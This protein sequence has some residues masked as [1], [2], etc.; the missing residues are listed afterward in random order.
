MKGLKFYALGLCA[1][2]LFNSCNMT[3]TAKGG[4]IGGTSGAALGSALGAILAKS[5]N[6]GKWEIGRA[7]V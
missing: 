7:H 1:A 4:M 3:N 5:G 6:K 2:L